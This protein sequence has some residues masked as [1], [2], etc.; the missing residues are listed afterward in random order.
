[1]STSDDPNRQAPPTLFGPQQ[2][3][4]GQQGGG[5]VR[6]LADLEGRVPGLVN[7]RH[8][9]RA[10]RTGASGTRRRG[11]FALIAMLFLASAIVV[12]WM[13]QRDDTPTQGTSAQGS[14][15][16][17]SQQRETRPE[18]AVSNTA[19]DAT[20]AAAVIDV[21]PASASTTPAAD[22]NASRDEVALDQL[23]RSPETATAAAM[24]NL[25]AGSGAQKPASKASVAASNKT[26]AKNDVNIARH[27]VKITNAAT[28]AKST[29]AERRK[30]V[31]KTTTAMTANDDPDADVLAALMGPPPSSGTATKGRVKTVTQGATR[32]Q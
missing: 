1:M 14:L 11:V 12:L 23:G 20:Q 15:Q 27:D 7:T 5:D 8:P 10:T 3:Q 16:S 19:P 31:R 25:A 24:A 29:T 30:P 32:T 18:T 2:G 21:S 28:V 9:P 13:N 17:D 6:I 4:P 26:S 22:K